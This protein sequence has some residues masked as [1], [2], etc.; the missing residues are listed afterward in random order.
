MFAPT[1]G[2]LI[3]KQ[4]TGTG[5]P[6]QRM[7]MADYVAQLEKAMNRLKAEQQEDSNG[8]PMTDAFLDICLA[9]DRIL[10]GPGGSVL[11]AGRPGMG[12]REAVTLVAQMHQMRLAGLDRVILCKKRVNCVKFS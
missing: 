6:M 10:T 8:Q 3:G 9:V 1:W 4:S 2:P 7:P 12:R 5:M 11:L